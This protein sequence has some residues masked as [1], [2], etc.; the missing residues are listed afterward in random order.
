[1]EKIDITRTAI[2]NA[3]EY[4]GRNKT[5]WREVR[6]TVDGETEYQ[7]R[8]IKKVQSERRKICSEIKEG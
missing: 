3:L 2:Q 4:F 1:M 7:Q 6:Q 5:Y 8:F